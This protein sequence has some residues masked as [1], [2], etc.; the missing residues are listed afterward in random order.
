MVTPNPTN[1]QSERLHLAYFGIDAL[2]SPYPANVRYTYSDHYGYSWSTHIALTLGTAINW[3]PFIPANAD[4]SVLTIAFASSRTGHRESY[5]IHSYNG[6][7]SWYTNDD[8]LV[9]VTHIQDANRDGNDYPSDS[10]FD[11]SHSVWWWRIDS[12]ISNVVDSL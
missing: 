4:Y 12:A 1:P 2:N 10:W 9:K 7:S 3:V 11:S 8:S 5:L 6:G